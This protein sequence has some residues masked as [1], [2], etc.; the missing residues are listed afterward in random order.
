M[1]HGRLIYACMSELEVP[2]LQPPTWRLDEQNTPGS[3]AKTAVVNEYKAA[4]IGAS[5]YTC[6]CI[7]TAVTILEGA[8]KCM[9]NGAACV[10]S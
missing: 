6:V 8:F 2:Q 5:M 3:K 9:A 1:S 4:L 7:H 10:V